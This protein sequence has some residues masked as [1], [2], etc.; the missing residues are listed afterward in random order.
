MRILFD[1]GTPRPLR[2]YLLGHAVETS[3]QRG[4][5]ELGNGDLLGIAENQGFDLL[6]TTDQSMRYQQNLAGR[7]LAVIVLLSGAWPY[8]RSRID[9]IRAAIAKVEPGELLEFPILTANES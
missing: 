4:W 7:R 5:S 2:D 6:I 9:D 1:Q 8:T 3:A